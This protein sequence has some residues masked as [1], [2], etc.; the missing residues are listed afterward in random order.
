MPLSAAAQAF[1]A[2]GDME[3][4]LDDDGA[5]LRC[6]RY[7]IPTHDNIPARNILSRILSD[8]TLC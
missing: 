7:N 4:E 6:H 3:L 8:R 2:K 5:R 1:T